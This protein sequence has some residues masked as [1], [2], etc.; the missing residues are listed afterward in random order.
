MDL[1]TAPAKLRSNLLKAI[2]MARSAPP[3]P[4]RHAHIH[5]RIL[6]VSF[7]A[8]GAILGA[9]ALITGLLL[10]VNA[11]ALRGAAPIHEAQS[12]EVQ[13]YGLASLLSNS[14]HA[15]GKGLG[16]AVGAASWVF[17]ALAICALFVTLLGALLFAAGRGVSRQASWAR[18]TGGLITLAVLA[19][20]AV[21]VRHLSQTAAIADGVVMTLSLYGL[22]VLVWRFR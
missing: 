21:V 19:S 15:I 18:F 6:G 1:S 22:W 7:Q 14:S 8:M 9:S 5:R 20:G 13:K 10:A 4:H 17:G 16:L 11:V 2:L 3:P 12:L